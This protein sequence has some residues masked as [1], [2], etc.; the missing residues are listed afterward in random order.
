MTAVNCVKN[1][2]VLTP[3]I[4]L[5]GVTPIVPVR[6]VV[7]QWHGAQASDDWPIPPAALSLALDPD[8]ALQFA[9]DLY[10]AAM[11]QKDS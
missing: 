9:I 8:D 2:I 11:A 5:E 6:P 1:P 10:Y 3:K 4:D 7:I